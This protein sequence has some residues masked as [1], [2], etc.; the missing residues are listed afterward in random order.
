MPNADQ[1]GHNNDELEDIMQSSDRHSVATLNWMFT[2]EELQKHIDIKGEKFQ[3][4][5]RHFRKQFKDEEEYRR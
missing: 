1:P 5:R 4:F 3:G 2:K